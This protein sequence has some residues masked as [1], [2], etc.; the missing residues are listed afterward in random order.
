MVAVPELDA[1]AVIGVPD[2]ILTEARGYADAQA[3]IQK[4]PL[5]QRQLEQEAAAAASEN[6]KAPELVAGTET[7]ETE[8]DFQ[9]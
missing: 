8:E 1:Y 4:E 9:G 3:V 5:K 2:D 7:A 6:E